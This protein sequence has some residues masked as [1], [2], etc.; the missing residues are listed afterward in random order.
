MR[1]AQRS[2][3]ATP[4]GPPASPGVAVGILDVDLDAERD[5][6]LSYIPPSGVIGVRCSLLRDFSIIQEKSNEFSISHP[7]SVGEVFRLALHG[8]NLLDEQHQLL[9]CVERLGTDAWESTARLW[10]PDHQVVVPPSDLASVP[11]DMFRLEES[12]KVP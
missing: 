3:D 7:S 12:V 6:H 4:S 9:S 11:S 2:D 8:L 5:Y 10:L 1:F